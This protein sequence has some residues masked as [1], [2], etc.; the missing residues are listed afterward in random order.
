MV[1]QRLNHD[2]IFEPFSFIRG[3]EIARGCWQQPDSYIT[4]TTPEQNGGLVQK[5]KKKKSKGGDYRIWRE[6]REK[7]QFRSNPR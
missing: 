7:N 5:K 3:W 4:M 2:R 6:N 1:G